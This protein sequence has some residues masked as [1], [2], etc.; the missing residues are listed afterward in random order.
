MP[1]TLPL[2]LVSGVLMSECASI[3][4]TPPG[5]C[6]DARPAECPQR[7]RVVASEDE[8]YLTGA[9]RLADECGDARAC[10]LDL[11]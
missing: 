7:D 10:L 6:A 3:Q 2:G 11:G 8:R 1:W 4:S 9:G 5:P